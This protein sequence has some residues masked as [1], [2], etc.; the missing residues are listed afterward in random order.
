MTVG[1]LASKLI[2]LHLKTVHAVIDHYLR[3]NKLEAIVADTSEGSATTLIEQ[4]AIEN[5][6]LLLNVIFGAVGITSILLSFLAILFT[7]FFYKA[8]RE[9]SDSVKEATRRIENV[10]S[11][12]NAHIE[13]I[14]DRAVD[15]WIGYGESPE[16]DAVS[17]LAETVK[18]LQDQLEELKDTNDDTPARLK[19][20]AAAQQK[21]LWLLT[22]NLREHRARSFFGS[23]SEKAITNSQDLVDLTDNE[24]TGALTVHVVR[25][26]P[27]A[28]GAGKLSLKVDEP[29]N[30]EVE[31]VE[32]P[33]GISAP[34]LKGVAA[35][36]PWIGRFNV[37]ITMPGGG[38]VPVGAYRVK[39]RA[40]KAE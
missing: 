29:P 36:R 31:F 23:S 12:V 35:N 10:V 20:L 19:A 18:Q 21:Q 16:E 37:H 28:T 32:T 33:P 24:E 5:L 34:D 6:N 1:P 25:P 40:T 39:Y 11:A 38:D 7:W 9:Q 26:V 8:A 22:R 2:F 17:S 30:L 4:S 3:G 27:N 15:S 14:I 13:R